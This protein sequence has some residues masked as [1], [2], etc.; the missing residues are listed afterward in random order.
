MRNNRKKPK[1]FS[2]GES[3]VSPGK[4]DKDSTEG[5]GKLVDGKKSSAASRELSRLGDDVVVGKLKDFPH[6]N[7]FGFDTKFTQN[8]SFVSLLSLSAEQT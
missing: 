6:S 3:L 1:K 2:D 5:G 7:S 8:F 4:E